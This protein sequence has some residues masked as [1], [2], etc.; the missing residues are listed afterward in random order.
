MDHIDALV[1]EALRLKE[2]DAVGPL[3]IEAIRPGGVLF[4]HDGVEIEY[5]VGR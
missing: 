1:Q 3:V 5:R 2:G 4:S